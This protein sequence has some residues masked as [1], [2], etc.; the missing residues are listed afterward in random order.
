[1]REASRLFKLSGDSPNHTWHG[2]LYP[3]KVN[4]DTFKGHKAQTKRYRKPLPLRPALTLRELTIG[5][6]DT[7]GRPSETGCARTGT[8]RP[9]AAKWPTSERATGG[10]ET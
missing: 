9:S 2:Q 8:V 5:G 4:A 6:T 7:E 3:I 10:S 1:M